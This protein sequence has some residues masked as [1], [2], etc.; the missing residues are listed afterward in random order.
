MSK[1]SSTSSSPRTTF[2]MSSMILISMPSYSSLTITSTTKNVCKL[3]L[4]VLELK[5]LILTN[6]NGI[7]ENENLMVCYRGLEDDLAA[8]K[9]EG[10]VKS[11]IT[12]KKEM[13][14]FPTDLDSKEVEVRPQYS[15]KTLNILS[16][17][18]EKE[19]TIEF[20]QL[21]V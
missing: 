13:V 1:T 3:V 2:R 21:L 5:Q 17:I 16:E 9:A 8:L 19:V 12:N 7:K 4:I 10:W 11:I 14:L 15:K 6:K 18:W 20:K